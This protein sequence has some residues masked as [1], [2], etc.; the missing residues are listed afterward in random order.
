MLALLLAEVN[1]AP[2]YM[3]EKGKAFFI[4][5]HSRDMINRGDE[6]FY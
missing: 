2:P 1:N 3:R 6:N 5:F 4:I